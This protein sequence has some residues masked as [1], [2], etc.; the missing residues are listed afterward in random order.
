MFLSLICIRERESECGKMLAVMS[1]GEG[2]AGVHCTI[3][4]PFLW[5]WNFPKAGLG[6][7]GPTLTPPTTSYSRPKDHSR[8]SRPAQR[9][10][11][12]GHGCGQQGSVPPSA[13]VWGK[14]LR[15]PR[16]LF[17]VLL[18]WRSLTLKEIRC[19]AHGLRLKSPALHVFTYRHVT[20]KQQP[21]RCAHKPQ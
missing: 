5:T 2:W 14:L 15:N 3:L 21:G 9:E 16:G 1:F 17:N 11:D 19:L 6:E 18:T 10:G 7:K 8:P 12:A 13:G 4:S 20:S